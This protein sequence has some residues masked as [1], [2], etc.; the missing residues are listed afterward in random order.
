MVAVAAW[1][2]LNRAGVF[3]MNKFGRKKLLALAAASGAVIVKRPEG[4]YIE[5]AGEK[6]DE[7]IDSG[8]NAIIAAGAGVGIVLLLVVLM[9]GRGG[10]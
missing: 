4:G 10:D 8:K 6:K 7:I 3:L 1:A 5:W 2:F 9:S